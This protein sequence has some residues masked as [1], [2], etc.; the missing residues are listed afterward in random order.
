LQEGGSTLWHE[1]R[2]CLPK[3]RP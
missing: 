2:P 1:R 3:P